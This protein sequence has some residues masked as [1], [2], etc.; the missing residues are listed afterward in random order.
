MSDIKHFKNNITADLYIGQGAGKKLLHDLENAQKSVKIVSPYLSPIY[1]EKL[2]YLSSKGINITLITSD[3][4]EDYRDVLTPKVITKLI[5][6]VRHVDEIA[7]RQREK[8][9]NLKKWLIIFLVADVISNILLALNH[10]NNILLILGSFVVLLV[11]ISLSYQIKN[12][13]IFTYS[14]EQLFPFRVFVSP[15]NKKLRNVSS[16]F[17]H[18]KIYIIDEWIAYLGSLN[19]TKSGLE[20]NFESRIRITNNQVVSE[21][22]NLVEELFHNNDENAYIDVQSWG[23]Q[24]YKEPIN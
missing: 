17:I 23:K 18:S 22:S 3:D 24:L 21:L 6:Q 20:T 9:K 12:K 2:V 4:I 16:F 7:Q 11:V 14:Y 5:K 15:Y 8:Q 10:K 13:R 1:I 19:Y